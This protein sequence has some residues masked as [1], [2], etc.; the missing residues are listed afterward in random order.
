[1]TGSPK[2]SNTVA[3]VLIVSLCAVA[4]ILYTLFA[5][6]SSR[7]VAADK[8][9][10]TPAVQTPSSSAVTPPPSNAPAR[11]AESAPPPAADNPVPAPPRPKAR[12]RPSGRLVAL[13]LRDSPDRGSVEFA[14]LDAVNEPRT[15][16]KLYCERIYVASTKGICLSR[17][18]KML[19][20]ETVATLV[21]AD[22]NPLSSVRIDGIPT[23]ARVSRDGR[24]AAFTVF[25]TGHSYGD[26]QMSTAT[27]LLDVSTGATIANLEQ[28][29]VLRDGASIEA[30]DMNYWG[31]TFQDDSNLFYATLRTAG[32]NYLVRGDIAART[33]TVIYNG[34]ECPSLSPDGTRIAFKKM[35]SRNNWRLT[36]LD[37]ATLKETALAE[38]RSVDDQAEW[39]DNDRVLY[40]MADPAPWMS[41]MVVAADGTGQ[42][43][44]FAKGAMS[45]AVVR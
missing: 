11:P 28:F 1:M 13:N 27:L 41:I 20:A 12:V 8:P 6:R 7:S 3:F 31:V 10:P 40:A 35:T 36:T 45:P 2:Q 39:L 42:P 14:N 33:A 38:T 37:L 21:D 34:V 25:V 15:A 29:K 5:A 18:I 19:N 9:A 24:F 23:R 16:T 4:A 30:P 17:Q 26:A 43:A 22:F 44:V 32:V